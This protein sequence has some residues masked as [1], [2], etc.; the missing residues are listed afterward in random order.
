MN[1]DAFESRLR[2]GIVWRGGK[3]GKA[4]ESDEKL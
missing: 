3:L 1:G 4:W 2:Y